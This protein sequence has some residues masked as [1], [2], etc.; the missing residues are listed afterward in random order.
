MAAARDEPFAAVFLDCSKRR[1]LVN[2]EVSEPAEASSGI[3]V[4]CGLAGDLLHA[5]LQHKINQSE[6]K[7]SV[8]KYVDDMVLSASAKR[9]ASELREAKR[10]LEASGMR[11]NKTKCVVVANSDACRLECRKAWQHMGVDVSFTM[12]RSPCKTLVWM[13]NGVRGETQSSSRESSREK[14][15]SPPEI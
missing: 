3:P 10:I 7:E 2:G 1:I 15:K 13:F 12:H 14:V 6:L 4:G 9:C 5:F 8:L 11:L